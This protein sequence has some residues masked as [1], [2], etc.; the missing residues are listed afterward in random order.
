MQDEIKPN[1][2]DTL[3]GGRLLLLRQSSGARLSV[4]VRQIKPSELDTYNTLDIQSMELARLAYICQICEGDQRRA[5]TVQDIDTLDLESYSH[6]LDEDARQNFT[7]A[8]AHKL[9]TLQRSLANLE[10]MKKAHPELY[11]NLEQQ[12]KQA[13]TAASQKSSQTSV[14]SR[15]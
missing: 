9:R 5:A 1:N 2:A 7:H 8:S 10:T 3:R 6:L 12:I 15:G 4:F 11:A 13:V 14:V